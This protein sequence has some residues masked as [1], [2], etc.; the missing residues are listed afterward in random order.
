MNQPLLSELPSE[1][2]HPVA[3]MVHTYGF[4]LKK[5][6]N[7]RPYLQ[8]QISDKSGS[9]YC[10][11]WETPHSSPQEEFERFKEQKVLFIT[12]T[13]D[14]YNNKNS[15]SVETIA[16]PEPEALEQFL[17]ENPA[18]S[19]AKQE[20]KEV[21]KIENFKEYIEKQTKV[22]TFKV[23]DQIQ[24]VFR[25]LSVDTVESKNGSHYAI[26]KLGDNTGDV[27][28]KKFEVSAD[29]A[30]AFKEVKAVQVAGFAQI[31]NGK[32][33]LKLSVVEPAMLSAEELNMLWYST[34]YDI[35]VLKKEL[36]RFIQSIEN[37]FIRQ[38]CQ[39]FLQDPEVKDKIATSQAAVSYHHSY[40]G[41]LLTHI[42]RILYLLESVADAFNGKPYPN[43]KYRV[44][45]DLLIVG[46]FLHDLYKIREYRDAEYNPDGNLVGHLPLGAIQANR[47]MD[48]IPG[49]PDEIRKQIDHLLL[50]HHGEEKYG[51]P[52]KPCTVEAIILHHC[53]N[54]AAKVDPMFEALDALP[55]GSLWT[56]RLKGIEKP[57]YM[58][59]MI[60][61]EMT[62]KGKETPT[63]NV[64]N[65]SS[66][67]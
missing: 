48:R 23:D 38:L 6:K 9:L 28:A 24:H 66:E 61:A 16:S 49:F 53:D 32:F 15:I 40:R 44:N 67:G 33:G 18:P 36:W 56:E 42:V 60:I 52:M 22:K 17:A 47:L 8:F 19:P 37:P 63:S 5:A 13:V 21:V 65:K 27:S 14:P 2:G 51:S 39:D 35:K 57:A 46:G 55:E 7:N 30:A 41:G 10:K 59:G 4:E 62:K 12:G 20:P 11:K 54:L 26:F 43:G 29:Y 50:A 31:Y 3:H 25:L 1:K 34:V 58:G 64:E 45:K